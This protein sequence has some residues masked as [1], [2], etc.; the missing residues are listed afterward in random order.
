MIHDKLTYF[1][2]MAC[3]AR[4]KF[5]VDASG[6]KRAYRLMRALTKPFSL[7]FLLRRAEGAIAMF[8]KNRSGLVVNITGAYGYERE[9]FPISYLDEYVPVPFEGHD[10]MTMACWHD[11]LTKIYGDYMQPPP[12]HKRKTG[13]EPVELQL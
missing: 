12:E 7:R 10:V 5:K 2:K 8:R 13:H 1:L 6:R 9:T 11:Y 4:S 3:I